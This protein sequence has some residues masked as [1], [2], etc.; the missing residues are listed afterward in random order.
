MRSCLILLGGLLLWTVHFF[1]L[2]GIG[3][4]A[5]ASAASRGAVLLLSA[6]ALG[7]IGLLARQL[8]PLARSEDFARWRAGVALGGLA[9]S[10]LAIVWQALPAL[11]G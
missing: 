9:L 4:F 5:G 2:Y 6:L 7:A 10:A 8:L 1:S 11:I 3:E